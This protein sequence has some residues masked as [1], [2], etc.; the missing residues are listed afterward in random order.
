MREPAAWVFG[1]LFFVASVLGTMENIQKKLLRAEAI[2]RDYAQYCPTD[3][4]W[5]WKGE[6]K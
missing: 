2:E 4:K 1:F 6:C 3:G 5:A